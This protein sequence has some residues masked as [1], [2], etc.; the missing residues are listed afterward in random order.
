MTSRLAIAHLRRLDGRL[1]IK[2]SLEVSAAGQD[3]LR[4]AVN[5]ISLLP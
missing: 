5:E 2:V 1:G 4:D 3:V